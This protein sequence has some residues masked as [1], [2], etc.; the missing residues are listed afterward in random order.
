MAGEFCVPGTDPYLGFCCPAVAGT[1]PDRIDSDF[2]K[3][4]GCHDQCGEIVERV[5]NPVL[6]GFVRYR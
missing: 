6:I 3:L 5:S 2:P 1:D 4:P